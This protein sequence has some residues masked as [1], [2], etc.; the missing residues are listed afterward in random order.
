MK[1]TFLICL[2]F[3]CGN[4]SAQKKGQP[5]VDSLE[6]ELPKM[7]EDSNKVSLMYLIAQKTMFTNSDEAFVYSEKGLQL[8]EKLDWKKGIAKLHNILGLMIGDTGNNVLAKEHFE[9]S[10]ALN[11]ELG[12]KI[13]QVNNLNNI[14]RAYN[15]ESDYANAIDHY[16]KALTLAEELKNPDKIA[17]VGTNITATYF[18]QQNYPKAT[19]YAELTLKNA[20]LAKSPDNMGKALS[21]LG[22][23]KMDMKDSAAAKIYL[24][25][26]YKIYDSMGNQQ[27]VA[28]VLANLA[29]LE[30][31][32]YQ[33]SI[34]IMLKAQ[35][36]YDAKSPAY[37]GSIDNI[38]NL[39]QYY[40]ALAMQSLPAEKS[41]YLKRSE[42]YLLRGIAL[43]KQ[44]SNSETLANISRSLVD[45]EE[46]RGNYQVALEN[47]KTYS[48]INDSLFSQ[49]KKNEISGLEGKHNIAIKDNE[50]AINQLKLADQRRTQ[51]GLLAGL[52]LFGI[53]G[54]LLYWQSRNRKRTNTTLMVLNNQ[55]DEANKVKARFFG[56]LSHDLRSPVANLLHFLHLQKNDPDLLS[57]EQRSQHQQRISQSAEDLLETMESML[58]WSKEQMENFKPQIRSI[59]IGDLFDYLQKFFAQTGHVRL[60]FSHDPGM[61]VP[62]DENYLR[63]IMQNLTSNAIRALKNTP[64][65]LIEWKARKDGNNTMLSITD[66]GPGI[67]ADQVKALYDDSVTANAKNGFGLHLIRDLAKAIRYKISIQSQ[68]GMGTTFTL[69]V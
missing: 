26:A 18:A 3:L 5:L 43:S 35:A 48:T 68:P 61:M 60:R 28:G 62:A 40:Y 34:A 15:R 42:E 57:E 50:I 65:A 14:G 64:D 7:K 10:Y 38:A 41:L 13:D 6:S 23:I 47:Y 12:S 45:L 52:L 29:E 11:K 69:S 46:A 19:E 59:A 24:N 67:S 2:A 56:I 21:Q 53:I 25:R 36:I 22:V 4:L 44:T 63:I 32:N 30:Y 49:G 66:N 39:G 8:A 9:K 51:L 31:P 37:V 27:Q 1:Y 16:F 58:L 20:E 55:L 17:L 33:R 54:G